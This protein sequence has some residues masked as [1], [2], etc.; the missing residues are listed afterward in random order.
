MSAND[1]KK[2]QLFLAETF[3]LGCVKGFKYFVSYMRGREE[4]I[5]KI[6]NEPRSLITPSST[7]GGSLSGSFETSGIELPRNQQSFMISHRSQRRLSGYGFIDVGLPPASPSDREIDSTDDDLTMFLIAGY[8]RYNCP[9]VW[10]RSNHERLVRLSGETP[11]AKDNPLKL[12]STSRWSEEDIKIWDIVAELVSICTMPAP[13]NPF[14]VD[15]EYFQSLPL[16][17]SVLATGA[18]ANFLRTVL[19]HKEHFY[20]AKMFEDLTMVTQKH[21]QDF[22]A[23][24]NQEAKTPTV[25]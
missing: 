18:M 17:E 15:I 19:A 13:K 16:A 12:D 10:V 9:Y 24:S 8:S 21:F 5:C 11:S 14:A 22:S 6:V 3:R 7:P 25:L 2:L 20:D 23:L 4:L 1:K